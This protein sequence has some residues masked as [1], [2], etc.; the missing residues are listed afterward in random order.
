MTGL[1]PGEDRILEVA[2]IATGWD[3]AEVARYEA[4]VRVDQDVLD[5]RMI[6]EF[7]DKYTTVRDA[8]KAQ[9]DDG[10]AP[11]VVEDELLTFIGEH[12]APDK[13]V[14][15]AGNSIHQ[16]RKFI[17]IEWP[18]LASKLHYRMC[19]VS[20]WKVVFEGKYRKKFAKP[21]AH[22][23]LEDIQGSIQELQYYLA[24]GAWKK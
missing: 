11:E 2:V 5:S 8:L 17:D 13:P 3:F 16:D 7:W 24:K 9:N 18:R 10:Q 20:A 19:D 1:E 14:L 6:G 4:V 21:E 15:L 12:F 22:R 23:A